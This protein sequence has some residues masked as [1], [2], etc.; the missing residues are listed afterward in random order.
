MSFLQFSRPFSLA[1]AI[2]LS[3]LAFTIVDTGLAKQSTG[4]ITTVELR[5]GA[6]FEAELIS[7]NSDSIIFSVDG[8]ERTESNELINQIRFSDKEAE[9]S[10][11]AKSVVLVDKTQLLCQS[12]SVAKREL[13]AT[14]ECDVELQVPTRLV[15]HVRFTP[16]DAEFRNNWDK[17]VAIERESDALVVSRDEKLQM[18]DGLVGD[19]GAEAV[20]F[21]VGDR[22]A[23]VKLSRLTGI[24]FYRRV[25]DEFTPSTFIL[26]LT[27]GSRLQVRS[28]SIEDK[29]FLINTIAG[30]KFRISPDAISSM[31]F[32][33]SREMWLTEL[34]PAT[35][36]WEPLISGASI[37]GNLKRF[38]LAR[39]DKSF[40][41]K[42]LAVLHQ[43]VG[44][45]WERKTYSNGF[46]IKGGGRLSFL[47]AKQYARLS[48]EIAFDPDT[49]SAG[50]VKLIIQVDGVS[51]VEEVLNASTMKRPFA[52]DVDLAN[53]DRIVFHVEYHDR[54]SVG[55]ILHAVDMKLHR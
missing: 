26:K 15:D 48:G 31:D 41:G 53:S 35:N 51:R 9:P 19:V 22:T 43:G 33:T 40:G 20:S 24:L 17:T 52:I 6:E 7:V 1:H 21:T 34:D 46:A 44:Q 2:V 39:M 13:S 37:L 32:G 23:D 5:D 30:A 36:D 3:F 8:E 49:N 42:Q 55:D 45:S 29:A 12:F 10:E 28:L 16:G 4:F 38:S 11:I 54:R 50:V 25:T 27:D 14:C 18:I 47:L